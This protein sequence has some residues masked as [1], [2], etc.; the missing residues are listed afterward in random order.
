M[1]LP[2]RK[3]ARRLEAY[4]RAANDEEAA[5][6]LGM[7]LGSWRWW[8]LSRGLKP[9]GGVTCAKCGRRV[10]AR[11]DVGLCSRCRAAIE[12]ARNRKWSRAPFREFVRSLDGFRVSLKYSVQHKGVHGAGFRWARGILRVTGGNGHVSISS[13][14]I[15][16]TRIINVY[17]DWKGEHACACG[18]GEALVLRY[19]PPHGPPFY[20][21]GHLARVRGTSQPGTFPK[22]HPSWNRGLRGEAWHE[23]YS[24]E[25]RAKMLEGLRKGHATMSA[26]AT[27]TTTD[28]RDGYTLLATSEYAKTYTY[29]RTGRTWRARKMVPRARVVMATVLGR[30][31]RDDEIVTHLNAVRNDDRPENLA[32]L[33][34]QDKPA[35]RWGMAVKKLRGDALLEY[36]RKARSIIVTK[37]C[38]TCK[39]GFDVLG[40]QAERRTY[41]SR[42]CQK[43]RPKKPAR[44]EKAETSMDPGAESPSR[45]QVPARRSGPAGGR[46][47]NP[48]GKRGSGARRTRP[49][50]P[51]R[52][53]HGPHGPRFCDVCGQLKVQ[54][55]CACNVDR[56]RP[57]P[58][59]REWH[60][61]RERA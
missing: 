7:P 5:R 20:K 54:G 36:V 1:A 44:K 13:Q 47:A 4:E 42:K 23:A 34:V 25:V 18:C 2:K 59:P 10:R 29:P 45:V 30:P 43:A 14:E 33:S 40:S 9:R 55:V 53:P 12:G 51:P 35:L 3:V 24:P 19:N 11:G 27:Y 38:P 15:S 46:A 6:I 17:V 21:A 52:N 56:T 58:V 28:K 50:P 8:R 61:W 37:T 60:G 57:A 41:C 48:L 31:L 26:N 32:V 49:P 22:G 39:K 16:G